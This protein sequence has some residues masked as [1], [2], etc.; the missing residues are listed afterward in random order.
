MKFTHT[1][2]LLLATCLLSGCGTPGQT[3]A[4]QHPE[5]SPAHLQILKTGKVPDGDAIAGM[6]RE[7]VQIAMGVDPAQYTKVDGHDAWVYVRKTLSAQPL[8]TNSTPEI[9]RQDGR[10]KGSL[11]DTPNQSP[12]NQDQTKTTIVF[13]GNVAVHAESMKG[14]L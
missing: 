7:Q 10:N 6:T 2:L 14:G 11:L 12:Q 5:L 9:D 1:L 13:D 3:Y 8:T 4:K